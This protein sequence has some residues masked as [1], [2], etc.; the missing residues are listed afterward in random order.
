MLR[1]GPIYYFLNVS[2]LAGVVS[3]TTNIMLLLQASISKIVSLKRIHEKHE[4]ASPSP[5]VGIKSLAGL[6]LPFLVTVL[7]VRFDKFHFKK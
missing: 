1:P 7:F 3:L 4:L 6:Y 2:E 5:S